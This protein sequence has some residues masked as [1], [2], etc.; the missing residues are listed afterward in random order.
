MLTYKMKNQEISPIGSNGFHNT[1][2][3]HTIYPLQHCQVRSAR[4]FFTILLTLFTNLLRKKKAIRAATEK[5]QKGGIDL[6]ILAKKHLIEIESSYLH[7]RIVIRRATAEN[8]LKLGEILQQLF[9]QNEES[10]LLTMAVAYRSGASYQGAIKEMVIDDASDIWRFDVFAPFVGNKTGGKQLFPKLRCPETTL[11]L[12]TIQ[13]QIII[14]LNFVGR[15]GDEYYMIRAT[16]LVP[17]CSTSD[18][19][20]S[21]RINPKMSLETDPCFF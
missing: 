13:Q 11:M 18:D 5:K 19:C 1:T 12:K 3:A 21:F 6:E 16:I 9:P 8:R 10:S 15:N 20:K 17:N 4:R 2:H 14:S 7:Q